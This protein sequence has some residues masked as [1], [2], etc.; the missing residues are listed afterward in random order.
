MGNKEK[1]RPEGEGAFAF[2]VSFGL[3]YETKPPLFKAVL[4]LGIHFFCVTMAEITY[5]E[6]RVDQGHPISSRKA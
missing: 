1:H 2:N 5:G 6:P 3:L 4:S